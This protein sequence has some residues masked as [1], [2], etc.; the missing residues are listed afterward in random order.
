[1]PQV[2]IK[3]VIYT[4]T[5]GKELPTGGDYEHLCQRWEGLS[6]Q[7]PSSLLEKC[8]K[9]QSLNNMFLTQRISWCL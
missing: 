5:D 4:P 2:K 9:T 6:I 7:Q 1:M 8:E 3:E